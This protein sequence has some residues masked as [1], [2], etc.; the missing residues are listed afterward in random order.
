MKS[1]SLSA[2]CC[3]GDGTVRSLP[4]SRKYDV[5]IGVLPSGSATTFVALSCQLMLKKSKD[6]F[7]ASMKMICF[8]N[9][10]EPALSD[11]VLMRAVRIMKA[12][13][14]G[15]VGYRDA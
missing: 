2:T 14:S 1:L 10:K 8:S 13:A 4:N 6:P 7:W 11:I 15:V 9:V 3:G 5:I 12:A